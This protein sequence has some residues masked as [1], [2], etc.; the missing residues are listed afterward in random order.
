[1][2]LAVFALTLLIVTP[3]VVLRGEDWATIAGGWLDARLWWMGLGIVVAM[4]LAPTLFLFVFRDVEA[5]GFDPNTQ[6]LTT[7]ERRA[8]LQPV[9]R[10]H[11]FDS[12]HSI[13]PILSYSGG[14]LHVTLRKANGKLRQLSLGKELSSAQLQTQADWLHAHFGDLVQP[15]REDTGD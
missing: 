3:V 9:T 1:M 2:L 8:W 13:T 10:Q 5:F 12:I 15:L 6:Q 4:A 7:L 11:A 14:S